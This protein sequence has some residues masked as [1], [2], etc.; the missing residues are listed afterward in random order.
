MPLK[1]QRALSTTGLTAVSYTSLCVDEGGRTESNEK[2]EKG[3]IWLE[4][5]YSV[6]YLR[7][8]CTEMAC[9]VSLE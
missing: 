8:L 3:D 9:G 6:T 1:P 4:S 7:L 2:S 5:R